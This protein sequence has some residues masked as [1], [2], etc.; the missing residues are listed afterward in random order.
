MATYLLEVMAKVVVHSDEE[1]IEDFLANTYA[2]IAEFVP[3]D[4]HIIDIELDAFPLPQEPGGS[5]D[6]GDGADSEEGGEAPVS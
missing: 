4:E 2:R 3:D 5:P 6:F 1:S